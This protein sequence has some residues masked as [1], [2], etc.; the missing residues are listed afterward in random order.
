MA[1][2]VL[3]AKVSFSYVDDHGDS[4]FVPVGQRVREGHPVTF[5]REQL[6]REDDAV[7]EYEA[8]KAKANPEPV[9]RAPGRPAKPKE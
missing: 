6:F 8:P 2:R 7:W 1:G 3:V 9:K 5:D 4:Q